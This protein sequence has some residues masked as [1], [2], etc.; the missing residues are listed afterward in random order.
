M[1]G[2]A[3]KLAIYNDSKQGALWLRGGISHTLCVLAKQ[4]WQYI[5]KPPKDLFI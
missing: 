5:P 3:I 1:A 4:Q 2:I